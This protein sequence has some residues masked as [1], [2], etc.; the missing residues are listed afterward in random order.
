MRIL[1][2]MT[3]LFAVTSTLAQS[4]IEFYTDPNEVRLSFPEQENHDPILQQELRE[5]GAWKFFAKNHERWFALM[6]PEHQLPHRAFGQ[7]LEIPGADPLAKAEWF[8]EN[9]LRAF[10][11]RADQLTEPSLHNS[12][13]HAY[14]RFGQQING[15]PVLRSELV[16]KFHEGRLIMFG[17]DYYADPKLPEEPLISAEALDAAAS[18]G[19]DLALM[20]TEDLGL[21][22]LPVPFE[23]GHQL[24]FVQE[25][26]VSGYVNAVPRR[27]KTYVDAI[28]GEVL[29]RDNTVKHIGPGDPESKKEKKNKKV[30]P[31]GMPVVVSGQFQGTVHDISVL[32]DTEV[33]QM[34]YLNFNLGGQTFT[35]D[36][37]GGFI[38]NVTGP[39]QAEVSLDG[40]YCHIFTNG[41][42][43]SFTVSMNDGYNTVSIDDLANLRERSTYRN[44]NISW[45]HMKEW[46]PN[47]TG[48]DYPL[49]TN[50][51]V[52]GECNAFYDGNSINFYPAGGGCN[53][54]SLLKEVV[55]HEYGHG[56]NDK[57]YQS[58]GAFYNNGAMNEG[59]ADFWAL[60][61][62]QDLRLAE[63]F[64]SDNDDPLRRYDIDP[65]IY[66]EDLI[67]QVHNDGEIIC[68]AWM[69][70]HILL[71][72]DWDQTIAL[73][74]EAF[75]GLQA[76]AFNGNEGQAYTDV[77]LDALQADDDDGDLSNGTPNG[78]AIIQGFDEH[79]I[80]L[81]AYA[82]I[83]HEPVEFAEAETG[84]TLEAD[85]EIVFP[86]GQ[87]FDSMRAYYRFGPEEEWQSVIMDEQDDVFVTSI[88]GQP[89]ASVIQYYF[90]IS[91]VFGGISAVNPVAANKEVYPNLPHF[92]L[93]GVS[94]MLINDSDDYSEFGFFDLGTPQ[95]NATTG[96]WDEVEPVGSFADPMDPSSIVAPTE[97]HTDVEFGF[98]FVT[99]ENPGEDAAIGANDVDGGSTTLLS[100]LVDLTVYDDP[101]LAYWRWYVNAPP[102]GANPGADWWQVEVSDDGGNTWERVENTLTQDISWRRNAFKISEYVDLTADFRFRFIASDSVRLG[103]HLDGGSLIEA[104]VD[105]I[106][107]YDVGD[108]TSIEEE[109]AL[110]IDL[111]P[112][113]AS[114]VV[115]LRLPATGGRLD[116]ID[117]RGRAV[118][119]L[120][121]A[122][123]LNPL[124]DVSKWRAGA[125]F[126]RYIDADGKP[127][128]LRFTVSR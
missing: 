34:P 16:L 37:D 107:L 113:P 101:V 15:V 94:P 60:S 50:I 70:T 23:R 75:D 126:V 35:T 56:I 28:T 110:A 44:T 32:E 87:Y 65:K 42:T 59:Y 51:D 106:V 22:I 78:D 119:T 76:T 74:V 31:M 19:L 48:L 38:T 127:W 93:V 104:A 69:A 68:G 80:T 116:V 67:G 49:P 14:V 71:G 21:H 43:P 36:G 120:E 64:Y 17:C 63:G 57:Y 97:D 112:N 12:K 105:D 7:P 3:A 10:G 52:V 86:F 124:V 91:D 61:E 73:F 118:Y 100:P 53:A 46:L 29:V 40:A 122:T 18:A 39:A 45:E 1:L 117:N 55:I 66:P 47:F 11:V 30:L 25:F 103:Q 79:G 96:E 128:N 102:S 121:N 83:E 13:K 4:D 88:D 109:D 54:T 81:F 20:E 90:G 77:L 125:Y 111:F 115:Q 62:T 6:S 98:A 8:V 95:D 123:D 89:E 26:M 108:G 85:A 33:L 114:D 84:I 58:Q 41:N 2:A 5:A 82:D 99:G 27:Y 92:T 72:E 9:E 24:R